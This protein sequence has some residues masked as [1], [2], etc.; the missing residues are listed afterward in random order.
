MIIFFLTFRNNEL[1]KFLSLSAKS[2][3]S[4]L[5]S[6]FNF[7]IDLYRLNLFHL[8]KF[9]S[10]SYNVF[11]VSFGEKILSSNSLQE[12]EAPQDISRLVV[13]RQQFHL[14]LHGREKEE[15]RKEVDSR[16]I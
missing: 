2:S 15:E 5:K 13:N 6:A 8:L 10:S 3:K 9:E 4:F 16:E 11:S 12:N 7:C 14:H 1:P